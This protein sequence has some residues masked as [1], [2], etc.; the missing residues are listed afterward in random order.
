M[1]YPS[2]RT[3]QESN[4]GRCGLQANCS[5]DWAKDPEKGASSPGMEPEPDEP[6]TGLWHRATVGLNE[7]RRRYAFGFMVHYNILKTDI[8]DKTDKF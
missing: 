3:L 5:T 1:V 7:S 2:K 6:A 4:P 8:V